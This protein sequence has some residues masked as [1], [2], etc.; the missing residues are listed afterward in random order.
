V[1]VSA[2][3]LGR[4]KRDRE[5]AGRRYSGDD[6]D[7]AVMDCDYALHSGGFTPPEIKR[8]GDVKLMVIYRCRPD[9]QAETADEVAVRLEECWRAQGAFRNEAH[10]IT[11]EQAQ[12]LFDFLT[13]WDDNAFYTGRIEVALPAQ[14][15]RNE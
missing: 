15:Q 1:R 8:T 13:W 14:L 3:E 11:V 7:G 12:V 5:K 4:M 10:V 6:L 2:D 9:W